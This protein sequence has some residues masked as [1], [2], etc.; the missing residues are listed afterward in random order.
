MRGDIRHAPKDTPHLHIRSPAPHSPTHFVRVSCYTVNLFV[1]VWVN[2]NG[3]GGRSSRHS[4]LFPY[5]FTP[6]PALRPHSVPHGRNVRCEGDKGKGKS[7]GD[8]KPNY[9]YFHLLFSLFSV[10]ASSRSF[11][12][13]SLKSYK[14]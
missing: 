12:L 8:R 13:I 5:T 10:T 7:E 2:V 9:L 3:V 6:H 14:V 4:L 11:S 1:N